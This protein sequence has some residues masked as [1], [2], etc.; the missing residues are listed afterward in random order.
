M[1][2]FVIYLIDGIGTQLM[3]SL[4]MILSLRLLLGVRVELI[5]PLS[6]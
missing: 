5:M 3:S 4:E 6:M 1:F 2:G